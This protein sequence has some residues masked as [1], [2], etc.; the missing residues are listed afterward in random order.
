M[1]VFK[2]IIVLIVLFNC[3]GFAQE[4]FPVQFKVEKQAMSTP[5][6]VME[7]MFFNSAYYARP[8]N[9]QFDGVQLNMF[10]DNNRIVKKE[11]VTQVESNAD[12]DDDQDVTKRFYYT[13]D[14]NVSDTIMLVVDYEIPYVQLVVPA[15]NSNGEKIG[16]T[17]Y[18]KF[19][20]YEELAL[21]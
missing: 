7:E 20:K 17:S 1:K 13:I 21:R 16:Y 12:F 10:Y 14:N 15:K 2:L 4:V 6:S 11:N 5:M 9:I 3:K 18:Q 19:V 8:I